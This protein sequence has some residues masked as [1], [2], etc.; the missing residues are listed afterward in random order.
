MWS[1]WTWSSLYAELDPII[2]MFYVVLGI[3]LGEFWTHYTR[4]GQHPSYLSIQITIL[5]NCLHLFITLFIHSY[6]FNMCVGQRTIYSHLFALP[7]VW[8]SGIKLRQSS[9]AAHVFQYGKTHWAIL[10]ALS[11]FSLGQGLCSIFL[12]ISYTLIPSPPLQLL[13]CL[14]HFLSKSQPFTYFITYYIISII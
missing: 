1:W 5:L 9:L 7:T 12:S 3:K 13:L 2:G 6:L 4:T 11:K 14:L 10:S 8:I